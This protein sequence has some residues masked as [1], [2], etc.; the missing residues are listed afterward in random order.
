MIQNNLPSNRKFGA[1]FFTVFLALAVNEYFRHQ[2]HFLAFSY[3]IIAVFFGIACI[4][5][6]NILTP[7]NKLWFFIGQALGKF[8]SPIVLGIIFF[9]LI[10][11]FALLAKLSGRDELRL[12]RSKVTSYWV[13]P[14]GSNSEPES[15][16]DQF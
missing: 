2:S 9:L 10:T 3:F 12:K 15:F 16:K 8:V 11:P 5:Y 13:S 4:F 1:L 6:S 14:V 7:L